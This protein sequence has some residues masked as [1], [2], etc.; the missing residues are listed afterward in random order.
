MVSTA[1]DIRLVHWLKF[2]SQWNSCLISLGLIVFA[3]SAPAQTNNDVSPT[4]ELKSLSLEELMDLDVTSVAKEPQPY[5][6]APAA[7]DVITGD[8]I[9]R[10]GASS[11]PEALR[12][13][14][15]MGGG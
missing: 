1:N 5:G 13:G 4:A 2:F 15:T 7:I 8:E 12:L 14:G 10:S 9:S 11:I 3:S 6:Q